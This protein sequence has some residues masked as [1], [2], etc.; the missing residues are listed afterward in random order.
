MKACAPTLPTAHPETAI[1]CYLVRMPPYASGWQ[2][3]HSTSLTTLHSRPLPSPG[4]RKSG[5]PHFQALLE[6]H[7]P[8]LPT[9]MCGMQPIYSPL[10][11]LILIWRATKSF[12][13]SLDNTSPIQCYQEI[14]QKNG[15][16]AVVKQ[17]KPLLRRDM[18]RDQWGAF[19]LAHQDWTV[20]DWR[21]VV[22]S[23]EIKINCLGPDRRMWAWKRAGEDLSDRLVAGSA[24]VWW[25]FTHDLGLYAVGKAWICCK[26]QWKMNAKLYT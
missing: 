4:S 19:A 16:K 10:C 2:S 6:V 15:L 8:K 7:P 5:L 26:N 22:W 23:N 17:K 18:G 20:V 14:P 11:R 9:T 21:R 3:A 1:S 13:L 24:K 12:L 25:R